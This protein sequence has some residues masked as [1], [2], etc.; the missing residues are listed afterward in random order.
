[1]KNIYRKK[2][3]I[4]IITKMNSTNFVEPLLKPSKNRYVLFQ[5]FI[6]MSLIVLGVIILSPIYHSW[7]TQTHKRKYK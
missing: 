3:I 5:S 2:Y 7:Y 4:I 6:A 1:M